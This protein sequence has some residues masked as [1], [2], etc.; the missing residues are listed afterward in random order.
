MIVFYTY[1]YQLFKDI[2]FLKKNDK[3]QAFKVLSIVLIFDITFVQKD[4]IV[5]R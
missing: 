2:L 5:K 1:L 3:G 4:A